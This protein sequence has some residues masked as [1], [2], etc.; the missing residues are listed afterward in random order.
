VR[1]VTRLSQFD[2]RSR[3]KTW[4]YRVAANYLLDAKKSCV[5]RERL[6][7][8]G[9]SRDLLAGLSDGGPADVE[10]SLLTEEVKV[11]CTLAMLQCLD[12]PHRLA[13][14]LGEIFDLPA[15]EAADAMSLDPAVFRKRLQRAR[16]AVESF[17]RAHCGLVSDD[18]PCRCHRRVPAAVA[19]GRVRPEL[20]L[21]AERSASFL[22]AR[23]L[24]SRVEQA[25]R[26]V[27]LHRERSSARP[28][29]GR[30]PS[31]DGRARADGA[32]MTRVLM[33]ER[34]EN[35]GSTRSMSF[36]RRR[37]SAG[38]KKVLI[39]S[40]IVWATT[41]LVYLVTACS[42]S[43]GFFDEAVDHSPTEACHEPR[44]DVG[45]CLLEH[46]FLHRQVG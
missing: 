17:T 27:E 35:D 30:R 28:V 15:P 10:L 46:G 16:E 9:F 3:L 6:S 38:E 43:L 21:F 40:A 2:F 44:R 24:I 19:L 11:G 41:P 23:D 20:P 39:G 45:E 4:A 12:R 37:A 34:D 33:N 14:A 22:Q 8:D 29:Q 42:S 26:V 13:Y 1:V 36:A 31:C 7:F 32:R 18:A 25:Q 5:E